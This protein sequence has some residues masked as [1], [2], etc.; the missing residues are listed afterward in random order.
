MPNLRFQAV[1]CEIAGAEAMENGAKVG[2]S[3][4]LTRERPLQRPNNGSSAGCF[5]ESRHGKN[6]SKNFHVF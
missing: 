5:A 3:P 6:K 2:I 1:V 4:S